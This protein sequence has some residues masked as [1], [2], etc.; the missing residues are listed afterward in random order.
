MN[1]QACKKA[2]KGKP[3]ATRCPD[4]W[5]ELFED[6]K[7]DSARRKTLLDECKP[8]KYGPTDYASLMEAK[9]NGLLDAAAQSGFALLNHMPE[10]EFTA[11]RLALRDY[12]NRLCAPYHP[13]QEPQTPRDYMRTWKEGR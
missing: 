7:S 2:C 1:C 6:Y 10:K 3:P 9:F 12:R 13:R 8:V 11:M 5:P 4:Y